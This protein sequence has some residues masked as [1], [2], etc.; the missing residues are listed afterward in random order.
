MLFPFVPI[1][2]WLVWLATYRFQGFHHWQDQ[3]QHLHRVANFVGTE[4]SGPILGT[5]LY[6]KCPP[7]ALLV[8]EL[9]GLKWMSWNQLLPCWSQ[10]HFGF[11]EFLANWS[12]ICLRELLRLFGGLLVLL[13]AHLAALEG[14]HA[15]AAWSKNS[16]CG[17]DLENGHPQVYTE[18]HLY[19]GWN[20][21]STWI[22]LSTF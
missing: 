16:G 1:C 12:A 7:D 8:L 13:Q 11:C 15:E 19:V 10:C 9:L 4:L 5:S 17:P 3:R 20:M 22:M 14:S 2:W 6:R 21:G 18:H